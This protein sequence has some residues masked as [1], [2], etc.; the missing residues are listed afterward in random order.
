MSG[1]DPSIPILIKAGVAVI[2]RAAPKGLELIKSW[3]KGKTILVVGQDRSG[4]T[5]FV[6]YFQ[7]GLFEDEKDTDKTYDVTPS[8]RFNV[9]IG[10]AETLEV[11]V[12]TAV[13]VPG[14][15]GP[16]AHADLVF[17]SNPH[18][19]LIFMDLTRPLRRDSKISSIEWLTDFCK[20]LEAK[21]RINRHTR[22]HIKSI[23]IVLNKKDKVDVKTIESRKRAFQKILDAELKDG[24]GQMLNDV[25]IIPCVL[26]NNSDGTKS[27]DSVISHL[28]KALI[29]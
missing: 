8:A 5:T 29:K 1:V 21:W 13:D 27:A 24:R 14:Q 10:K 22:N 3:W 19:V 26:I 20:R 12:K 16:I 25:A 4:K 17:E 15:I 18:A 28:A 2:Q 9:K 23:I 11:S 6:D 7:Y